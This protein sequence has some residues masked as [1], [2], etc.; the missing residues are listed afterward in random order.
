MED[1]DYQ[2][3]VK[4]I[5][6]S[7]A[8]AIK[9]F[10]GESCSLCLITETAEQVDLDWPE[11]S[12]AAA[13]LQRWLEGQQRTADTQRKIGYLSCTIEGFKNVPSNMRPSLAN[14]VARMLEQFGFA[15]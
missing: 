10:F 1:R 6:L 4:E 12:K 14:A 15:E 5:G 7:D 3:L 2:K 13:V 9:K 11:W 8:E